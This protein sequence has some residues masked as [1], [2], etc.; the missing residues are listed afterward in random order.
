LRGPSSA[1]RGAAL[2]DLGIIEDGSVLIR[3][4]LIASIGPTRRIENLKAARGA[5][6]IPIEG[7]IVTP[8]FI[9]AGLHLSLRRSETS[10]QFK[11]I[12]D[13]Y[14]DSLNL[15]R[16]C[17]Q[18]GTI[19]ADVKGSADDQKFHSDIAVFRKLAKI[20]ST[21]VRMMRTWRVNFGVGR[22][23][24]DDLV[25]TLQTLLRRKFIHSICVAPRGVHDFDIEAIV[26]AQ[27]AGLPLKMLWSGASQTVLAEL[28]HQLNPHS[29]CAQHFDSLAPEALANS[30]AIAVLAAGKQL[31]EGPICTSGRSLIDA[32]AAVA[33]SSGYQSVATGNFSMQMAIALAVARL[34]L[35]PEEAWSAATINAAYAAGCGDITGSLEIGK[36]ADLLVLNV[37]DYRDIPRQFGINHV[38]MVF[39]DGVM[40]LNRTRWRSPAEQQ[41]ARRVRS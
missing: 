14:E 26:A 3:D 1:R 38:A 8:G 36:Q 21:P 32:G 28:L 34:G 29:V 24:S 13:F 33:L 19:T 16:L 25:P 11:R 4:G 6:E 40:V 7:R 30:S 15:M 39:R 9:D 27:A 23:V 35:T 18:H 41:P 22:T 5:Q 10:S 17:L 2:Q 37:A 31:F 20:G 12:A